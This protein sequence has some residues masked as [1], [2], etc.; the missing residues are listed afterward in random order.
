MLAISDVHGAFDA[1]HRV[2]ASG[3]TVLILGDLANLTDY[4]TGEGAVASALGIDFA[5]RTATA[6]GEGDFVEM[7]R[8][9]R[10]KA[11]GDSEAVRASIVQ[12]I[13]AQYDEVARALTGGTG[14]V[15]HG[16]VDRP[17]LLMKALPESFEY[18]HGQRVEIEGLTFGFV[19]GG[20]STPLNAAG[21]VADTDM[22]ALLEGIGD[23]DV[24]CTHVAPAL[25]PLRIDVV[26]GR[27]ERSSVPILRYLEEHQP[28]LHLF[29]DVHQPRASTWRVGHTR[30]INVGYFRAT[31]RAHRVILDQL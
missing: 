11:A 26:T 13:G 27:A 1:L 30:C 19:G 4:R 18:V 3:E 23:V 21:E 24:L 7:R 10:E 28:R 29:G 20:V 8:M 16:N 31:G 9:W 6:R 25:D 15:M 5:R 2:I 22:E 12:M 14:Y 17:D